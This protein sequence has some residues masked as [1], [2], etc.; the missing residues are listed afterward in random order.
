ME[1]IAPVLIVLFIIIAL[2]S[3]NASKTN[4]EPE[5]DKNA[6]AGEVAASNAALSL[7]EIRKKCMQLPNG[8]PEHLADCKEFFSPNPKPLGIAQA[9]EV[10]STPPINQSDENVL[11]AATSQ[12]NDGAISASRR[13]ECVKSASSLNEKSLTIEQKRN[14]YILIGGP[15]ENLENATERATFM[16]NE[17][18]INWIKLEKRVSDNIEKYWIVFESMKYD[19]ADYHQSLLKKANINE[20]SITE[21]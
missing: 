10:L 15:Y 6:K 14:E 1:K 7:E 5:A 3:N 18:G 17:T 2:A 12:L 4:S 8:S 16:A 21:K 9:D 19:G 11:C 20:F 13:N